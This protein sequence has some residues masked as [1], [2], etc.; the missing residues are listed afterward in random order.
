MPLPYAHL[1]TDVRETQALFERLQ[2]DAQFEVLAFSQP[3]YLPTP[4]VVDASII[5][6]LS[7]GV[8]YRV[9][10]Q[11]AQL[12]AADAALFRQETDAYVEAGMR[13]RAVDEVPMKLVVADRKTVLL[14][15][16][17]SAA[18]ATRYPTL[19]LIEHA[20]FADAQAVVF[21]HYWDSAVPYEWRA[22]E[23]ASGA[24]RRISSRPG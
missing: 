20:G 13:V 24:G 15:M 5:E 21:E 2:A 12:L 11:S 22:A 8:A 9:I 18:P 1:I 7:R 17:D 6:C 3:P 4:G 16:T 19:M 10:Y 23:S 14:G